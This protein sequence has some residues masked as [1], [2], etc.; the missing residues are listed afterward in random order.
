MSAQATD[1]VTRHHP[2]DYLRGVLALSVMGYH[3]NLFQNRHYVLLD[4]LGIWAV[5]T[6]YVISG[7]SFGFVYRGLELRARSVLAFFVKRYAR[8]LPVYVVA[9]LGVL[10]I[11]IGS[12]LL[13]NPVDLP[14]HLLT[15]FTLTFGFIDASRYVVTGGW[16]IGNELVYY[17][18]LP[19]LIAALR[20]DR[21]LFLAA[22][23]LAVSLAVWWAFGRLDPDR[24]LADQW[25][26]YI[27]PF[28]H[29]YLFALGV[30]VS[31][32]RIRVPGWVPLLVAL[33]FVA[34]PLGIGQIQIVTRWTWVA[35]TLTCTLLAA[36]VYWWTPDP[37]PLHGLLSFLGR[38]SYSIYLL[39]PVVYSWM[40]H[41]VTGAVGV[42]LAVVCTFVAA[43]LSWHYVEEPTIL[44]GKRLAG[45]IERASA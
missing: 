5:L 14:D 25:N 40:G 41:F 44:L 37:Q 42:G 12:Y 43:W 28:S 22:A 4:K 16:S 39:H 35:Y 7:I 10:G 27:S 18:T 13:G 26:V 33:V 24:A 15:N 29:W 23:G 32:T 11:P 2:L 8:L 19:L 45:R 3:Y 38:S 1:A 31:A 36:S 34:L 6:F 21:R 20:F 30:G 9:L 17:V